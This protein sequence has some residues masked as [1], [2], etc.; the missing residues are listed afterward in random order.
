MFPCSAGLRSGSPKN[1]LSRRKLALPQFFCPIRPFCYCHCWIQ[2]FGHYCPLELLFPTHQGTFMEF[3][4]PLLSNNSF[5]VGLVDGM[6]DGHKDAGLTAANDTSLVKNL[7]NCYHEPTPCIAPGAESL[8]LREPDALDGSLKKEQSMIDSS[9]SIARAEEVERLE[10]LKG[11]KG[12]EIVTQENCSQVNVQMIENDNLPL[13]S[14]DI[15]MPMPMHMYSRRKKGKKAGTMKD[16]LNLHSNEK[17][18]SLDEQERCGLAFHGGAPC[19]RQKQQD[20]HPVKKTEIA[21]PHSEKESQFLPACD[22]VHKEESKKGFPVGRATDKHKEG[23]KHQKL[24]KAKCASSPD[25]KRGRDTEEECVSGQYRAIVDEFLKVSDISESESVAAVVESGKYAAVR[26]GL[27]ASTVTCIEKARFRDVLNQVDGARQYLECR[28]FLLGLWEKDVCHTLSITDCG[29]SIPASMNEASRIRLLHDIHYFLNYHAFINMG[30]TSKKLRLTPD[31]ETN[32]LFS[33]KADL[34][35]V[36]VFS[37]NR[38][39]KMEAITSLSR[40]ERDPCLPFCS[41]EVSGNQELV[42]SGDKQKKRL[43]LG[44]AVHEPGDVD[45]ATVLQPAESSVQARSVSPVKADGI[46]LTAARPSDEE[47]LQDIKNRIKARNRRKKQGLHEISTH[48]ESKCQEEEEKITEWKCNNLKKGINGLPSCN[49][50]VEDS[51]HDKQSSKRKVLVVG[52]GPAGLAAARHLQNMDVQVTILEARDRIG[53]RAF[54][55]RMTFSGPVDLGAS[56]VRGVEADLATEARPD[57]VA[58]LCKQLNLELTVLQG[59][60]PLLDVVRGVKVPADIDMALEADFNCLLEEAAKLP[61]E[62]DSAKHMSLQKGLKLAYRKQEASLD[63]GSGKSNQ[64][65]QG[66]ST[67]LLFSKDGPS[68]SLAQRVLSWHFATLELQW[69]AE[70]SKISL[71][72]WTENNSHSGFAGP[73]CMIKGGFSA[74]MEAL[75]TGLE[76]QLEQ[77]VTE[78]D[79]L[80]RDEKHGGLDKI[81]VQTRGG[82]MYCADAVLLTVPLGCMKAG[83]IKFSPP[84]PEPKISSIDRLGLG[85]LNKVAMEFP[86][87][88]WDES[89]DSFG[90]TTELTG[91]RRR[92]SFFRNLKPIVGFPILTTSIVGE[93]AVEDE[94]KEGP[95]VVEQAL[96][97]LRRL[98]GETAV[99]QPTAFQVTRWGS[100]PHSRGSYSYIPVG[101]SGKDYDT[102][103]LPVEN[104]LFFAGEAT[105][106]E[107]PNTVGGA[108]M[109]GLREA[110]RILDVLNNRTDFTSEAEVIG[111]AEKQSNCQANEVK[112]MAKSLREG[113]ISIATK[114]CGRNLARAKGP[115]RRVGLL[116]SLYAVPKTNAGRLLLAKEMLQLPE[117]SL[118]NFLNTKAG[119]LVLNSWIQGAMGKD[120]GQ[121]L[122]LCLQLLLVIESSC[123]LAQRSGIQTT[124]KD[125][126]SKHTSRDV[127]ATAR[128]L[129][130]LWLEGKGKGKSVHGLAKPFQKPENSEKKLHR[131]KARDAKVSSSERRTEQRDNLL[132]PAGDVLQ[133][134]A[135]RKTQASG[136]SE[137]LIKKKVRDVKIS[138]S[139]SVADVKVPLSQAGAQLRG[140]PSVSC[141]DTVQ[142]GLEW[143]AQASGCVSTEVTALVAAKDDHIMECRNIGQP[144]QSTMPILEANPTVTNV[145]DITAKPQDSPAPAN[146]KQPE[147]PKIMSFQ[148]FAKREHIDTS[149]RRPLQRETLLLY[150]KDLV[151]SGADARQSK[152]RD[153]SIDFSD[154]CS[155]LGSPRLLAMLDNVSSRDGFSAVVPSL[156]GIS[157]TENAGER[158]ESGLTSNQDEAALPSSKEVTDDASAG[159]SMRG[160]PRRQSGVCLASLNSGNTPL[161]TAAA[162]L[163]D[164]DKPAEVLFEQNHSLDVQKIEAST[165]NHPYADVGKRDSQSHSTEKRPD[166]AEGHCCS[167]NEANAASAGSSVRL[168]GGQQIEIHNIEESSPAHQL[169]DGGKSCLSTGALSKSVIVENPCL[170]P[171]TSEQV[172]KVVTDYV[173]HL[174]T[175]LYKTKRI[176]KDSFKSIMKKA[177][178]KVMERRTEE[179][180]VMEPLEFMDTKRKIKIRSLIDKMVERYLEI[181]STCWGGAVGYDNGR[182]ESRFSEASFVYVFQQDLQKSMLEDWKGTEFLELKWIVDKH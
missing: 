178:A 157:S 123:S 50:Q 31:S 162:P 103:G 62:N 85:V 101:G 155:Y 45:M 112:E 89:V 129:L 163:N 141:R 49:Q 79:Y 72:N 17:V 135:E 51:V 23:L 13:L 66:K 93:A 182:L 92:C 57:P 27:R 87:C 160:S 22:G 54:T 100:D 116:Q 81:Q 40:T 175:P 166:S 168:A 151:T 142:G 140:N 12:E 63:I 7:Y 32:P 94:Q 118:R 154:S 91:T 114:M 104:Q 110:V 35:T 177:I 108:M 97:V 69:G 15:V 61:V 18:C 60:C 73:H 138:L 33:N 5:C 161:D 83:L 11:L 38:H 171:D 30:V 75:G 149:K 106:K 2:L 132:I 34:A 180:L 136:R 37:T 148:K 4:Q 65:G 96:S 39:S 113:G 167:L 181:T 74:V 76:I 53:G 117:S 78:I 29:F 6:S 153:W 128:K 20:L 169:L 144:M 56:I 170:A 14:E 143:Q 107:Y 158:H 41:K 164:D 24:A 82:A 102:V 126:V 95:E 152:V 67:S 120:G 121:L 172:K 139:E 146:A 19:E 25:K 47:F 44:T 124:L 58:L 10:G 52:A 59:D 119:L 115:S 147:L 179:E 36:E 130:D 71:S 1:G 86:K 88:F 55:D 3:K 105:C 156:P 26:A 165:S 90:C 159:S 43:K 21:F 173:A 42:A 64:A 174:L 127:R 77:E 176:S 16:L 99:P 98:F 125:K 68:F 80:C 109:S 145:M 84:L 46:E 70:L 150:G 9:E 111:A 133:V 137:P 134:A 8:S 122:R 28:N 131:K 48:V